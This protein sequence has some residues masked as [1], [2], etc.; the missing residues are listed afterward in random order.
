MYLENN[1]LHRLQLLMSIIILSI[2]AVFISKQGPYNKQGT[3]VPIPTSRTTT[4]RVNN[5]LF[6]C[7]SSYNCKHSKCKGM[8]IFLRWSQYSIQISCR[9]IYIELSIKITSS[10]LRLYTL[11]HTDKV[12]H[13]NLNLGLKNI[14]MLITVVSNM[15]KVNQSYRWNQKLQPDSQRMAWSLSWTSLWQVPQ[16]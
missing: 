9:L 5:C 13:I 10:E 15:K 6:N 7:I 14:N 4:S 12:C 8:K 1:T 11:V 3:S 16:G 2:F